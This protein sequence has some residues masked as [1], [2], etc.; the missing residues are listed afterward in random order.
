MSIETNKELILR[1]FSAL[2]DGDRSVF[3]E[4]R[5]PD[6][7]WQLMGQSSWA[8]RYEGEAELQEK[9]FKPLFARFATQFSTRVVNIIGDGEIVAAEVRGDV[10]THEGGRYNNQ[11]CFIFTLRHGKIIEVREYADTDLWERVL[12]SYETALAAVE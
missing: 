3:R 5:H 2:A 4:A 6:C 8:G 11:Y 10:T 7:V 12:G 9:L 1:C